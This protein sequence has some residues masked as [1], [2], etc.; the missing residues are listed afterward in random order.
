MKR[1]AILDHD[2]HCLFV[3]D[4]SNDTL[5]NHYNDDM[6][7][8]IEDSYT[9]NGAYSWEY[10]NDAEYLREEDKMPIEIDFDEIGDID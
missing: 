10:I 4:V 5:K 9:F 3:E 8:Y 1:I 6:K 7:A 2:S